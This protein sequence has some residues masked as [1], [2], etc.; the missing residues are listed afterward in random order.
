[1]KKKNTRRRKRDSASPQ[2]EL[3]WDALPSGVKS[4]LAEHID[5]LKEFREQYPRFYDVMFRPMDTERY[6][7]FEA[8][9]V[10]AQARSRKRKHR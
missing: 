10:E 5:Q 1:M 9:L 6:K 7:R 2:L 3:D 8:R 4:F